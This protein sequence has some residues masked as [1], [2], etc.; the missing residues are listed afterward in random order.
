[1][2]L[3]DPLLM[4]ALFVLFFRTFGTR[5]TCVAL[6]HL[7]DGAVLLRL[8]RRQPVALGLAVR[9]RAVPRLVDAR[10]RPLAAGAALGYAVASKLF[11][12][13]FG[14]GFAF[15]AGWEL[16]R[17]RGFDRRL[18]RFAAGAVAA[19][20]LSVAISSAMFGP[21]VWRGYE[22]RIAVAQREHFYAN[23]YS[24]RTVFLQAAYSTPREMRAQLDGAARGQARRA[25]RSTRQHW[26]FVL[27]AAPPDR[28]RRARAAPR[29]AASRRSPS[30]RCSSTSGSWSTPTTGTCWR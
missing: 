21:R 14:V 12:L 6:D 13:F 26:R 20:A 1:M 19:V 7:L 17:T 4:I 3:I 8:P 9:A 25:P 16:W 27:A 11:P 29:R 23:Q 30:G 28:A 24:F 22:Q 15:W 10:Q 2:G 5:P 18:V